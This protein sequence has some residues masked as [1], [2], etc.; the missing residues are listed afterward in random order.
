MRPSTPYFKVRDASLGGHQWV[1]GVLGERVAAVEVAFGAVRAEADERRLVV[2]GSGAVGRDRVGVRRARHRCT[3]TPTAR[4]STPTAST[5]RRTAAW[6]ARS[7]RSGRARRATAPSAFAL[8]RKKWITR[9][10]RTRPSVR[11]AAGPAWSTVRPR[12][13]SSVDAGPAAVQAQRR[14]ADTPSV[15][16]RAAS[17]VIAREEAVE[18]G[19]VVPERDQPDAPELRLRAH[20]AAERRGEPDVRVAQARDGRG[21]RRLAQHSEG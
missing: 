21:L 9:F 3:R 15:G 19:V 6:R 17:A 4:R 12:G 14:E 16:E 1:Q 20:R 18:R 10:E 5:S 8:V 7:P 11:T 13:R 2:E